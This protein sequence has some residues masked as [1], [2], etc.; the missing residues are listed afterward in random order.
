M[1]IERLYREHAP[2]LYRYVTCFTGSPDAAEDV[3]QETFIRLLETSPKDVAIR[4]WLFRVATNLSRDAHRRAARHT[5]LLAKAPHDATQGDEP[6]D[7]SSSTLA[8]DARRVVTSALGALPERDRTVLLM[9]EEGFTH[10]EIARAVGTTEKSVGT[11]IA[12]AMTRFARIL[13]ERKV[14]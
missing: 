13:E 9:R 4:G 6:A 7:A 11:F 3:V 12:R 1:D 2:A 10:A 5:R 14:T 8:E